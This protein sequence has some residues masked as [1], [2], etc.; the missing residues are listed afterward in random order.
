MTQTPEPKTDGGFIP[1]LCQVRA[2]FLLVLTT[3]LVVVLFALAQPSDGLLDWRYLGLASLLVQWVTLTAAGLICALRRRLEALGVTLTVT[4]ITAL[5][6][7]DTALFTLLGQWLLTPPPSPLNAPFTLLRNL[8]MAA[9]ITLMLLRYFHLQ[10]QRRRQEEAE[11]EARIAALQARIQPHF[12]F[13]SMNTIASLIVSEPER[14]EEVVLD[15]S[16]LFRA[17]LNT[18]G[19]RLITLGEELRLCERYLAIEHLRLGSRLHVE[20]AL[21]EAADDRPVPPLI[22]QPL[23]ENAV[24]HGI[25]PRSEGGT[26]RV[27]SE[28]TRRWLYI[29]IHNPLAS[30]LAGQNQGQRMALENIQARLSAVYGDAAALKVS[31]RES[32]FTVTLRLPGNREYNP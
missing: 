18:T 2:V 11:L 19:E 31:R 6:L 17:S 16:E 29:L 24:Y 13:N 20:W 4:I 26:I 25:Q 14:A 8:I 7:A 15:L 3:E 9:L 22:L 21:D 1:D 5:V 27:E 30:D 32:Q 28:L 12:L 23:L 10:Y